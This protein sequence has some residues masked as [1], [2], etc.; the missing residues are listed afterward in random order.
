[1]PLLL[2]VE[3]FLFALELLD[4]VLPPHENH[5]VFALQLHRDLAILI[6]LIDVVV[7]SQ[8]GVLDEPLEKVDALLLPGLR[9]PHA[10]EDGLLRRLLLLDR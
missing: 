7:L 4:L 8:L 2:L 6:V 3:V 5:E 1:M 10:R 9:K